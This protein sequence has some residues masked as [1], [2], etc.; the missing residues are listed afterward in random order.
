MASYCDQ[1]TFY[2][3]DLC[4]DFDIILGNSWLKP[5]GATLDLGVENVI[6]NKSGRQFTIH[7]STAPI[8]A[9]DSTKPKFLSVMQCKRLERRGCKTLLINVMPVTESSAPVDPAIQTVLDE[10]ADRFPNDLHELPKERPVFHTIPLQ[11]P[12]APPP[13]RPLYRLS[14]LERQEWRLRSSLRDLKSLLAKGFIEPSN[15]PYCAP[16]LFVQKKDTSLRMVIDFRALNKLTIKNRY[17]LPRLDDLLDGATGATVF[18]AT[19][20]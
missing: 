7:C 16:I 3:I 8:S 12:N 1:L 14:P 2:V 20:S 10:Y 6:I 19:V 9:A 4:T 15:S 5:L 18:S 11:D 17:P 13:F